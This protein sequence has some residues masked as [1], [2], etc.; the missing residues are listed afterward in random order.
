MQ[1]VQFK[2]KK[3]LMP[4]LVKQKMKQAQPLLLLQHLKVLKK[5]LRLIGSSKSNSY[6]NKHGLVYILNLLTDQVLVIFVT[7]SVNF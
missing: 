5:C 1:T 2:L 4:V 7:V 6:L 3:L